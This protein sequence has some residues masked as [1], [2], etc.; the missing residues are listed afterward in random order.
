MSKRCTVELANEVENTVI[1]F[2]DC[3]PI[4]SRASLH[5]VDKYNRKRVIY[6]IIYQI[7]TSISKLLFDIEHNTWKIIVF[8]VQ[9]TIGTILCSIFF[10]GRFYYIF[11]WM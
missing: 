8:I 7:N 9:P 5:T 1:T 6:S 11:E 3:N 4:L 10:P 2:T